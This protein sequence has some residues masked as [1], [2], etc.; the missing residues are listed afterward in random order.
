MTLTRRL[1]YM[2]FHK[3][4]RVAWYFGQSVE[5]LTLRV[6]RGGVL[7][8]PCTLGSGGLYKFVVK[9]NTGEVFFVKSFNIVQ[10]GWILVNKFYGQ[11]DKTPPHSSFDDIADV[12]EYIASKPQLRRHTLLKFVELIILE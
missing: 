1:T 10:Q 11:S 9:K 2:L 7:V 12:L 3:I 4:Y 8:K 5:V 6:R